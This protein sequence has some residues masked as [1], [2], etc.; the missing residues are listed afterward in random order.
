[1]TDGYNA[2]RRKDDKE[3]VC[4]VCQEKVAH[5]RGEFDNRVC[6]W[7]YFDHK[8]RKWSGRKCPTCKSAQST[9]S[10]EKRRYEQR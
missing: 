8:G 7:T 6:G 2:Y 3:R 10:T 5:I 1:M 4:A 9:G